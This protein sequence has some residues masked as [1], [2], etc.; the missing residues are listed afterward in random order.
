MARQ[1]RNLVEQQ[2][3]RQEKIELSLPGRFTSALMTLRPTG[4]PLDRWKTTA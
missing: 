2:K 3:K 1:F 4:P